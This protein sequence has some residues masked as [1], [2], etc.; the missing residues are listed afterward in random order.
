[1]AKIKKPKKAA[2]LAREIWRLHGICEN[3]G[4]R[5]RQL[6]GAHILGVGSHPRIQADIRNGFCLCSVC[7][8]RFHD[9]SYDFNEFINSSWAE[10]YIKTLRSKAIRQPTDPKV[11]WDL[12]I[13]Q[14]KEIKRAIIAKELTIIQARELEE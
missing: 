12:K 14:L 13:D 6:Q 7:H 5:D 1:V 9:N 3:C 4:A 8:R 2:N 11:D 10:Q